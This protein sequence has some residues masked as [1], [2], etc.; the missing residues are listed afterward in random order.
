M[1]KFMSFKNLIKEISYNKRIII[2]TGI[3]NY[4]E[5]NYKILY[6]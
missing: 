3:L 5:I 1:K 2:K 4:V 6:Y